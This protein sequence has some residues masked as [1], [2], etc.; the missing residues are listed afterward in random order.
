M[1]KPLFLFTKKAVVHM[2]AE[3][4]YKAITTQTQAQV[5]AAKTPE[6]W[7]RAA[8]NHAMADRIG[9]WLSDTAREHLAEIIQEEKGI[10]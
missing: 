9:Q 3:G 4:V 5:D 6:E 10:E 8:T 2:T 7:H 1:L